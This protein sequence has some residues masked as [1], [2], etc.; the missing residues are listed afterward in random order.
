MSCSR[1][2]KELE[3]ANFREKLVYEFE[4][5][6]CEGETE[7]LIISGV[8]PKVLYINTLTI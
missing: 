1:L 8:L 4:L 3:Q 5:A 2:V 6:I 7:K